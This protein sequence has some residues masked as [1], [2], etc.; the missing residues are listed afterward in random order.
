MGMGLERQIEEYKKVIQIEPRE[1]KIQETIRKSKEAFWVSEQHRMLTF[2]EFVWAQFKLVQK[3][4]W[5]FQLCLLLLLWGVLLSIQDD[6]YVQRSM[7]IIASLFVILIIPEIWKNR[8]HQS[9]E[10][11]SSSY[12]SL[13]QIYAARMILFGVVD[14][15]LLTAFL[16][17]TMSVLNFSITELLIEFLFPMTITACICLGTLSSNRLSE[18]AAVTLCILWSAIWLLIVLN[19]NVYT[20]ITIPI[21][22]VLL[23][24]ALIYL[25]IVIY[26]ILKK[27]TNYWE[28]SVNGIEIE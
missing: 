9:M 19:D 11:E 16:G 28:E 26:Q 25:G 22:S 14:T 17:M 1:E 15:L 7:G 23:A 6:R 12:Y 27:C 21:W 3:R 10:I 5:L 4:W 8:I 18:M 24:A 20:R 13:R 2:H